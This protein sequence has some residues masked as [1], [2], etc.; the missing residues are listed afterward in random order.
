MRDSR[1]RGDRR[2]C[3]DSCE[4]RRASEREACL[5]ADLALCSS[6]VSSFFAPP[7]LSDVACSGHSAATILADAVAVLG[8]AGWTWPPPRGPSTCVSAASS[9]LVASFDAAPSCSPASPCLIVPTAPPRFSARDCFN[10]PARR[11]P[12]SPPEACTRACLVTPVTPVPCVGPSALLLLLQHTPDDAHSL[13][14]L[15]GATRSAI[16]RHSHKSAMAIFLR[17]SSFVMAVALPARALSRG[18]RVVAV[19]LCIPS[20]MRI[21]LRCS[22]SML[23]CVSV[24]LRCL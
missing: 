19:L 9:S 17:A 16:D 7:S 24:S 14:V 10:T 2:V 20:W 6:S 11:P 12:P 22:G 8:P 23:L 4:R 1:S 18:V 13:A 5:S 3:G 15:H 21:L